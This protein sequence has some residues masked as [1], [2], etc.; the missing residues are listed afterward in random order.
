MIETKKTNMKLGELL[1]DCGMVT[2]EQVEKALEYAREEDVRIGEALVALGYIDADR[3]TWAIGVQFDL[4]YVDLQPEMI[5]WELLRELPLGRLLQYR[6]LPVS[7]VGETVTAV[8]SDPLIDGLSQFIADLFPFKNVVVLL[9]SEESILRILAE[10]KRY[11]ADLMAFRPAAAS[12]RP[13]PHD[14]DLLRL[15]D[16]GKITRLAAMQNGEEEIRRVFGDAEAGVLPAALSRGER[17]ALYA[18]IQSEF[19][20]EFALPGG[21]C[22]IRQVSGRGGRQP[23][24]AVMATSF[25]GW[26]I[27]VEA[28]PVGS[29]GTTSHPVHVVCGESPLALKA[30]LLS[31]A[32]KSAESDK[33]AAPPAALECRVDS[34]V[35]GAFQLEVEH[36]AARI[37][38]CRHIVSAARPSLT[39]LE[40]ESAREAALLGAVAHA[41]SAGPI[42]VVLRSLAPR[43][44]TLPAQTKAVQLTPDSVRTFLDDIL[45]K[46]TSP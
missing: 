27:A 33:M 29:P 28:I 46:A 10:A 19:K 43:E 31:A 8:I 26:L 21:F 12:R 9:S 37:A 36:A 35:P 3:L 41:P 17:E 4:S 23:L 18:R 38:V 45:E 20:F 22:G 16:T 32:V 5:D 1:V 6:M 11:Q 30:E 42:V 7:R 15:F 13:V 39:I 14:R 34:L 40:V 25:D 44:E 24:R 2:L